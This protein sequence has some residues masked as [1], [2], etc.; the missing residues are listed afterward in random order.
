MPGHNGDEH[1]GD[2]FLGI[3]DA[4]HATL[5]NEIW[6]R[7]DPTEKLDAAKSIAPPHLQRDALQ[8]SDMIALLR[9]PSL[10]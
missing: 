9:C 3:E 8:L 6:T 1:V 5:T 4:G 2:I 10:W 7:D